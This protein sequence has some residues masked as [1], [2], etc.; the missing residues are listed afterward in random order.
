M[1]TA[2]QTLVR[3]YQ[4]HKLRM[5]RIVIMASTPALLPLLW[6][7]ARQLEYEYAL[8]TSW[9]LIG[10]PTFVGC[11]LPQKFW[12]IAL[13]TSWLDVALWPVFSI[14]PGWTLWFL[15]QCPCGVSGFNVWM[16]VL[17][18]PASLLGLA[19]FLWAIRLGGRRWI[20]AFYAVLMMIVAAS[21]LWFFPQKRIVSLIGG[22]LHGPIY[23]RWIP[24][25][26]GVVL[27]RLA[28]ALWALSAII[29]F[30]GRKSSRGVMASTVG[31]LGVILWLSTWFWDSVGF[32]SLFLKRNLSSNISR[33]RIEM[34]YDRHS[35]EDEA[36]AR[37]L[38]RDAMF[39]VD[40]ISG[41]LG[42]TFPKKIQIYAYKSRDQK[43][44]M[45][46]GGDTDVTDVWTPSVHIELRPSPHPT[47]RHE[48]VHAVA[49][50]ISWQ[51]LGF[52]PNMLITEG[53]AM[54][55]APTA[56][57]LSF[58]QMAAEMLRSG[59]IS[60]A[61][62]LFSPWDFWTASG[63]R[64]Y[65][66]AGSV[67]RWI[68]MNFGASGLRRIYQGESFAD[69]TQMS[70]AQ[71]M[72]R[73]REYVLEKHE[74][75]HRM[76]VEKISREPG[77]FEERCPHAEEDLKRPR[78]DGILTRLRQPPGWD[79]EH[80]DDWQL[81]MNPAHREARL[82]ILR[83]RINDVMAGPTRDLGLISAWR[84]TLAK[85]FAW[86]PRVLEDLETSLLLLDFEAINDLAGSHEISQTLTLDDVA[87]TF[88]TKDPGPHFRRQWEARVAVDE[89][90][91]GFERNEWRRYLAGW[92]ELPTQKQGEPWIASYLRTRR[93]TTVSSESVDDWLIK[94]AIC[95]SF[96]EITR[97]WL[98]MAAIR[99]LELD[100]FAHAQELFDRLAE[101]TTGEARL[102]AQQHARRSSYL[103]KITPF[104]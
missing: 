24:V 37:Q 17:A 13:R 34:H 31:F 49:S 83:N 98:R 64:S 78:S 71:T 48:L 59:R 97:E 86:P 81:R 38:V 73:W 44:L 14:L 52:H 45:F 43:K 35:A 65:I 54:A 76:I 87:L 66:V 15:G 27:A 58:D 80:F 12:L 2:I 72:A 9:L 77:V 82:R 88:K 30:M 51:G 95:K 61:T 11:V 16:A 28:H 18:L 89:V 99:R 36:I 7:P 10:W 47:L 6:Q 55:L 60:D 33:D 42:V 104:R 93:H 56:N 67:L 32:G 103:A 75:G 74:D 40:E 50:F 79:S 20:V 69:V 26:W 46:G 101:L 91:S 92:G 5:I 62:S 21:I 68:H 41:I 23:D 100:Q 3:V 53:L 94:L 85:S 63:P 84:D 39:D 25:D 57:T 70:L 22:F 4:D 19:A 90:F 1:N 102:I 8:L 96:P 29:Y